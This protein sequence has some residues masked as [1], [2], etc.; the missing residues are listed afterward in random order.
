MNLLLRLPSFFLVSLCLA[1]MP[2]AHS[3]SYPRKPVVMIIPNAIGGAFDAAAR[4]LANALGQSLGQPVVVDN[5]PAGNGV[6]GVQAG[7]RAAPDGYSILWCGSGNMSFLPVLRNDLPYD[8][9]RDF[10][11]II[12]IGFLESFVMVHPSVP[13]NSMQELLDLAKAKP[14]TIT[15]GSWGSTSFSNVF[16]EWLK[17]MRNAYFYTVPYKTAPQA[18]NA[19]VAGEVQVMLFGQGQSATLVKGGKLRA[20]AA[21]GRKRS[22]FLPQIPTLWETKTIELDAPLWVGLVA[23]AGT[24]KEIVNRL[25]R[26]AGGLLADRNYTEKALVALGYVPD[27]PNSPE[28][29]AEFLKSDRKVYE[30]LVKRVPPAS[31]HEIDRRPC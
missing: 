13:A 21:T 15:W 10:T 1:A 26:I 2:S 18:L 9:L 28:E 29:F 23:P 12:R 6:I 31:L 27:D 11:P 16:I 19:L 24:P 20:L 7:A 5:R 8:A 30:D 17:K 14:N 25:N 3:Q 22:S 4:P